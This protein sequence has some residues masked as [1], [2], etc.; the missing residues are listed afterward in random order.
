MSPTESPMEEKHARKPLT[1]KSRQAEA[2]EALST[3]DIAD[4]GVGG[5]DGNAIERAGT[6]PREGMSTKDAASM[7]HTTRLPSSRPQIRRNQCS[8]PP[9][10]QQPPPPPAPD[11]QDSQLGNGNG[12]DSLSLLQLRRIV[13][14]MPKWEPTAYAFAY[15]DAASPREELDEWFSYSVEDRERLVKVRSA[16]ETEWRAFFTAE[17][18]GAESLGHVGWMDV[19]ISERQKFVRAKTAAMQSREGEGRRVPLQCLLYIALGVWGETASQE[20]EE[21]APAIQEDGRV[22]SDMSSRHPDWM[23]NDVL[24]LAENGGLEAIYGMLQEFLLMDWDEGPEDDRNI[25]LAPKVKPGA[26]EQLNNSL[27]LMYL[28]VE[29]SRLQIKTGEGTSLRDKIASLKPDYLTF[30]VKALARLRWDDATPLPL[31]KL[32]L[33]FWKSILLLFG[34]SQELKETKLATRE[35]LGRTS[36]DESRT[37]ITA[38]PLDYHLFRQ[39]ITSKYPA[40][41]PPPPLIPLDSDHNSILPPLPNQP[42]KAGNNGARS[43]V[44]PANI[45]SNSSSILHQPV[46]IATPAPSPPPSPVG[47]GGKV[48]KKQN[49]Q[50]NQNFPFLYPPLDPPGDQ[51]DPNVNASL[52]GTFDARKWERNDVPASILEAG[53]LFAD[54]MRMSRALRQLWDERERYL[55]F[56]RGWTGVKEDVNGD[57]SKKDRTKDAQCLDPEVKRRLDLVEEFYRNALPHLQ[58]LVIVLLKVVLSNVTATFSLPRQMLRN[59]EPIVLG[60]LFPPEMQANAND[61]GKNKENNGYGENEN[62]EGEENVL[63]TLEEVEAARSREISAKAVSGL[64]LLLL[65]W[66]KI[67]HILKFEFLTQ[68]LLDS[69]YLPLILKLFAHQDLEK[70]ID[71]IIDQGELNRSN[72][73][74]AEKQHYTCPAPKNKRYRESSNGVSDQAENHGEGPASVEQTTTT[75]TMTPPQMDELGCPIPAEPISSFS[76]RN[77]FSHINFLRIMQ[78]ICKHKA[79]RNLLLVQYKSST[80]LKKAL[81]VPQPELRLY[82]LKLFKNQVPY[83]GRKWRQGN[84]RVIT[85][86]YLHCRPELRDDWLAGSDVDSEVEEALPLEQALRALTHWH[87]LKRYPD[88]MG[89]ERRLLEDDQDFFVRELERM[90]LGDGGAA[91]AAAAAAAAEGAQREAG[92]GWDGGGGGGPLGLEGW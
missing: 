11:Q 87:N 55:R 18:G 47:P 19:D 38:S 62:G 79:H 44:G 1:S 30:L 31:T 43:G 9:P 8:Q 35:E 67:S 59:P 34:G 13:T 27:T 2:A 16:F 50:T 21:A 82:T 52:Q 92:A 45:N 4:I 78:K 17:E 74:P 81:K 46:H 84:M 49:Y 75:T 88:E 14:D 12:T 53:E 91:A 85:A 60:P 73:L 61:Q 40:Y 90:E 32:L 42:G 80:I 29:A 26:V 66:F 70:A 39:E 77:F 10:P 51:A 71:W 3:L 89:A 20:G 28:I 68:L 64:L 24:L 6:Q 23:L 37:V 36:D 41:D 83:C 48:G 25:D 15:D 69:N 5:G 58:S 86:V 76:W 63:M 22:K 54:R 7:T 57:D 65:K 33:L 56:E 72:Q